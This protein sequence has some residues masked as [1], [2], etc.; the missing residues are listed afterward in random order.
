MV[1]GGA[2][3]RERCCAAGVY[4][5]AAV[6]TAGGDV[7]TWLALRRIPQA[8]LR[9]CRRDCASTLPAP[10]HPALR[11]RHYLPACCRRRG[12][13]VAGQLNILERRRHMYLG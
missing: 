10:H 1:G 3:C 6:A 13:R 4:Y 12:I 8:E 7:M 2:E 9:A 5:A 11:H